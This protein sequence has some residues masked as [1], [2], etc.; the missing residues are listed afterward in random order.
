MVETLPS[1][2]TRKGELRAQLE[3]VRSRTLDL[4]S[5]VSDDFLRRRVHDFYSPIGWHFGHVG[6]TEE[7]WICKA[8][9]REPSDPGLSF[10]YADLA[11][12]PKDNRVN[13]PDRAGTIAYLAATREFV[14]EALET[15]NLEPG[16]PFLEDGYAWEFAIQ[17]ECQ[18]HETIAEMLHLIQTTMP[19][20]PVEPLRWRSGVATKMIPHAGGTFMMGDPSIHGY[21]NEK[22]QHEVQVDP[23]SLAEFPVTCFEWSEFIADGGY[24]RPE[25]W[26]PAGWEWARA[27]GA[28]APFYW[29]GEDGGWLQIG[30]FGTRALHPDEP[31]MGISR[32]EAEAYA[33]WRG[34]RLPTEA[35]WE[36]AA[37]SAGSAGKRRYSWG[38]S[39][40]ESVRACHG[41]T[42]W[43]PRPVGEAR[44][45]PTPLGVFD[46]SGNV[47]EWTSSRFAPYPGFEAFPYDGYSKDHMLG[48]HFVCRGGS[49]A[50]NPVILR[51][52][53]RN[54]YVPS[55]RQGFLGVRLAS[56]ST[57]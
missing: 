7:Y 13:I 39:K 21:D 26:T 47:W 23:F 4:L 10:I 49:W 36:F 52:S 56:D 28:V 54:W 11:D 12:N 3:D 50:T 5:N 31:V 6:R 57:W 34:S 46:M 41:M 17:H 51:N 24:S 2:A 53:F 42:P 27:N 44:E 37:S 1:Q 9:G 43:S 30:P 14:L 45:G 35:E 18:H 15:S 20:E 22:K 29:R 40:P 48:A 8:T 19:A 33:Y 25:L 16:N 55:Y 38:D 32:F